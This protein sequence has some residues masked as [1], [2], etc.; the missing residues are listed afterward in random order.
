MSLW[1]NTLLIAVD[2][3]VKVSLV[4]SDELAEVNSELAAVL[5]VHIGTDRPDDREGNVVVY[6]AVSLFLV[7]KLDVVLMKEYLDQTEARRYKVVDL[8]LNRHLHGHN[9]GQEL[10]KVSFKHRANALKLLLINHFLSLIEPRSYKRAPSEV[11]W[12]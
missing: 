9:L 4:L 1:V 2:G 6:D 7:L 11:N 10:I 12:L 5:V 3:S 8:S